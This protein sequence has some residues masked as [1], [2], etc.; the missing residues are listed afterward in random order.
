M[1]ARGGQLDCKTAQTYDLQRDH[2]R[3][4]LVLPI[5]FPRDTSSARTIDPASPWPLM[6]L[7][8]DV[9]LFYTDAAAAAVDPSVAGAGFEADSDGAD[10]DADGR[11]LPIYVTFTTSDL[12]LAERVSDACVTFGVLTLVLFTCGLVLCP[13]RKREL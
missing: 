5:G 13:A 10:G 7:V 8:H 2:D 1:L 3:Y 9:T 11:S 4:E 6:L 12:S